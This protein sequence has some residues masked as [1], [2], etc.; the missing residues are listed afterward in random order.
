MPTTTIRALD[1]VVTPAVGDKIPTDQAA[2]NVTRY[3]T[4][5][6]ILELL[7][8]VS[9]AE[10]E[11][12]TAT[13]RR[14]WTAE[15]VG[16][17][18]AAL[19]APKIRVLAKTAAYTV[20]TADLHKLIDATSGTWTLTLPAAAT[21]GDGFWI[22]FRNSGTGVITID[23]DGAELIDGGATVAAQPGQSGLIICNG[24]AWKTIGLPALAFDKVQRTAGD[25]TT[26]STSFVDLTAA[27][28]TITTKA[29]R[30][31]LTFMA[32]AQN[33]TGGES[34]YYKFI[35]DAAD[36]MG[37][38]GMLGNVGTANMWI[39]MSYITDVLTA[40]AHTFK[41]QWKVT[42][43]TGTTRGDTAHPYVFTAEELPY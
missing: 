33:N 7:P 28:I 14:A 15:R 35:A 20:T 23:P 6:Q 5:T 34:N 39:T 10:A 29:R 41:V 21:A 25:V 18:I 9:Q 12:G 38:D 8:T 2:D 32:R 13:T 19:A 17:A 26:T 31:R 36:I 30:V 37:T 43:G 27:S 40:A 1:A 22:A 11:A 24:T 16:Q 42:A 4:V 3:L